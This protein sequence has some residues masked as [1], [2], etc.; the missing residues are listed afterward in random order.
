MFFF[1]PADFLMLPAILLSLW[2]QARVH[3]AYKKYAAI[4]TQS[5]ITG[6]QV[7]QG[8]LQ[9]AQIHEVDIETVG[10]ELTD[11]YDSENKKLR[12]S[13]NIHQ[14]S[15]IA[16]VGIAAH[17]A[18]HALQDAQN[19]APMRMRHAIYPL[20]RLGSGLAFPLIFI[21]I[22]FNFSLSGI[23]IKAGIWLFSAAVAFTLI[24][25]PVEFDASRRAVAVLS[26]SG[27]FSQDELAGVRKVLNAAALT[28]VAAAATAALQLIRLIL[29]S[30]RRR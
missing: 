24:T 30:Q 3:G 11:H 17:E 9:G 8:I 6:A 1:H 14:G 27:R 4:Q 25:L 10:G 29:I 18:G 2:A 22:I 19:Y 21:G 26:S 7:A 15:S 20:S 13:Q 23:L 28:Y 12:L 16:A 5:G